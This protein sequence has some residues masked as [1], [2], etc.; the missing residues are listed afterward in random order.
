M[1]HLLTIIQ[2]GLILGKIFGWINY[3]WVIILLP[4]IIYFGILI[5]SFIIIGIISHIEHLKLNKLL[6]ELK[7]KK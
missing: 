5:M 6:K 2:A 4:L 3:R 1:K 7:V